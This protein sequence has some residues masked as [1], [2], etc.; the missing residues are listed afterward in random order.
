MTRRIL[1][2]LP[3][4]ELEGP[5]FRAV[6]DARNPVVEDFYSYADLGRMLPTAQYLRLTS[7]SMYLT[8]AAL[9]HAQA[10]IPA[11]P[12]QRVALDLRR[13][14]RITYALTNPAT[15]HIEVWA[16]PQI[17]LQCVV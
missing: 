4:T 10:S 3:A 6:H 16:P 1:E 11:L 5:V 9:R 14:S 8:E 7:V 12:R 13:D 17:L 15:G 2:V